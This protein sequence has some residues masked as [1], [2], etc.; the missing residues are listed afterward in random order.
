MAKLLVRETG[1]TPARGVFCSGRAGAAVAKKPKK[2]GHLA[3]FASSLYESN[4]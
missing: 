3:P 2:S 1:T 4:M